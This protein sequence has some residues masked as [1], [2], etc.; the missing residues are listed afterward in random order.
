[1]TA[2]T[3]PTLLTVDTVLPATDSAPLRPGYLRWEAGIL[4]EVGQGHPRP[5]PDE[6]WTHRPEGLALPGLVNTH[7]HL[8]GTITEALTEDSSI[9][10]LT[11]RTGD[12]AALHASIDGRIARAAALLSAVQ[13][14]RSGVTTT[15]DSHATWR[16]SDRIDGSLRAAEESGLRVVLHVAFLDRSELIPTDRQFDAIGAIEELGRLRA[17]SQSDLV[18]IEPEALSLPR[19]SD[20]LVLAVHSARRRLAA[21]HLN[22][23]REFRDWSRRTLGGGAV[24]HLDRLGVLDSGWVFAHPI[25]LEEGEAELLGASGAGCSYSPV[26]NLSLALE[27]PDLRPLRFAGVAIGVGIDHPNGS[28]DLWAS[29]RTAVLIQ[30]GVAGDV[31]TWPASDALR[32]A[33][34][35]GARALGLD[36]VTGRLSPGFS[37]DVQILDLRHAALTATRMRPE[38]VALAAHPGLVQDLAVRG[39]WL[40]TDG[41]LVHLDEPIIIA[42][43]RQV[44]EE[45]LHRSRSID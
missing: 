27:T 19:A 32:L 1:V 40:L 44:R 45:L 9:S 33:T 34:Q 41:R 12:E 22:Y 7:H 8:A 18:E 2:S 16:D 13:L 43:A 20:E 21:M 25:H 28:Q 10:V 37:A 3:S 35:E 5:R 30:R 42:E 14:I 4:T 39:E 24:Q 26:S 29:A 11:R 38:R 31:T 23:S 36:T 6:V 15:T 17:M